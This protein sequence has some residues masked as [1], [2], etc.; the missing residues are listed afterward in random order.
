MPLCGVLRGAGVNEGF[1]WGWGQVNGGKFPVE[2]NADGRRVCD[3]ADLGGWARHRNLFVG[4]F[5]KN[6]CL[7]MRSMVFS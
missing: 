3:P 7:R 1:T 4:V 5:E 2:R 6:Y